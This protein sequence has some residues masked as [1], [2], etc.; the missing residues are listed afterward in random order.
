MEREDP[1]A[2]GAR[3]AGWRYSRTYPGESLVLRHAGTRNGRWRLHGHHEQIGHSVEQFKTTRGDMQF[4]ALAVWHAGV[5]NRFEQFQVESL[6]G[7][8]GPVDVQKRCC[9]ACGAELTQP[10]GQPQPWPCGHCAG[11]QPIE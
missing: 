1:S 2:E 7:K 3:R 9:S 11:E 8:Y 6:V 4:G 10:R 5:A